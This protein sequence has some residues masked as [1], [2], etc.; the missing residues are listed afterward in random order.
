MKLVLVSGYPYPWPEGFD[1]NDYDPRSQE[2]TLSGVVHFEWR[3]TLT[4]EFDSLEDA[5][6]AL[7]NSGGYWHWWDKS[8]CILEAA[9]SPD[10]GYNHPAILYGD[11]AW[12]GFILEE[13]R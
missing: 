2:F 12:C 9:T 6:W 7:E 10:D 11:K 5:E 4:V 1:S 8:C 13:E 3:H